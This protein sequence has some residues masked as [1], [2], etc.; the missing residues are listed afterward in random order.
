MR[1]TSQNALTPA[2]SKQSAIMNGLATKDV[3]KGIKAASLIERETRR[4]QNEQ[5]VEKRKNKV[6]EPSI[7]TGNEIRQ[8]YEEGTYR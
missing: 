1:G 8:A 6:E 3:I 5:E 7:P 2:L 4:R